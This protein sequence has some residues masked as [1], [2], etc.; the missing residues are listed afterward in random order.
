M[1]KMLVPNRIFSCLRA[2]L[3]PSTTNGS[4][5]GSEGSTLTW[6][7]PGSVAISWGKITCSA[8]QSDSN[9]SVFGLLR[10]LDP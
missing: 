8:T 1:L 10:Q 3:S 7:S 4:N 2:E 9:P 6:S 5:K